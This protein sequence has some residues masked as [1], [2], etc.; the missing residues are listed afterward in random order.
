MTIFAV[1]CAAIFPVLHTGRPWFA[2]W[3]FPYPNE[4][5][6]WVNFRSPLIWD[7]FAVTTYFSVR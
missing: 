1:I 6:L 5:A 7:V 2:Y 4:R 3:L